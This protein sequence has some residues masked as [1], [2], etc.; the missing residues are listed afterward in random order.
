MEKKTLKEIAAYV[1]NN[2][3]FFEERLQLALDKMERLR[4]SL[5]FAD[6]EL[7]DDIVDKIEEWCDDHEVCYDEVDW[8]DAIDGDEGIIWEQ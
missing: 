6:A 7:F 4:C 2:V 3:E 1:R 5:H 8:D